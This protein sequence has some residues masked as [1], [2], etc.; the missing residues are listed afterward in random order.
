MPRA[1]NKPKTFRCTLVRNGYG[2][3]V[4]NG[5]DTE[6]GA[7]KAATDYLNQS[8][9]PALQVGVYQLVSIVKPKDVPVEVVKISVCKE[10]TP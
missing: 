7:V 8:R 1:S 6:A 4:G 2:Q 9:Q 10:K 3:D 5:Y